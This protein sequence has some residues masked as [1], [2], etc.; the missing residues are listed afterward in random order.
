MVAMFLAAR[1]PQIGDAKPTARRK[2]PF[3]ARS[4][5]SD[6][7]TRDGSPLRARW[8]LRKEDSMTGLSPTSRALAS[9]STLIIAALVV[10][11]LVFT[12]QAG[13]AGNPHAAHD[14]AVTTIIGDVD[15]NGLSVIIGSDGL[16]PYLNGVD[17][18]TSVLAA[19]AYN[20]LANGDWQFNKAN[21]TIRVSDYTFNEADAVQ[22]GDP[23]Y[24][25]PANPPYWGSQLHM[26]H[27]EV[28]C[29]AVF[30]D[31]LTMTAGATFTC[32]LLTTFTLDSSTD[33][34]LH[35]ALSFT[36]FAET[37]DVQVHCNTA[38]SGGCNDWFID[39][40]NLGEAV[41]RLQKHTTVHKAVTTD[42]G[43]F[44]MRFHFH[45]TRP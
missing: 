25:A 16:G 6:I 34:T 11:I 39:P 43:D 35:A 4:S 13:I 17:G 41:G 28:K 23:H 29:T 3:Q 32:P 14:I 15:S 12:P 38:D 45:I 8:Q 21:S 31:M 10:T 2:D 19:A 1:L 22:L 33:Y 26:S 24:Q 9:D 20:G 36:G 18:V 7:D 27:M 40:I 37:T 30:N 42:E 5:A 44:Y